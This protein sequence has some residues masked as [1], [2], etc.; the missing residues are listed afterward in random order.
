MA[1]RPKTCP[2]CRTRFVP[3][4]SFQPVCDSHE[5]R[6]AFV[7]K[8]IARDQARRQLAAKKKA[9][10]DKR[11]T[12]RRLLELQPTTYWRKKAQAVF[13]KMIRLVKCA[14]MPCISCG[15]YEGQMQAGHYQNAHDHPELAFE[16]D[17]VWIQCSR[18]NEK[19]S[20]NIVEYRKALVA[21]VGLER[22]EW[23]DS[24]QP[25]LHRRKDDYQQIIEASNASI[26]EVERGLR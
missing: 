2:E 17:N 12:R 5:C 4:R 13:N 1:R 18:C 19:K 15:T 3:S 26:K 22:V 6:V 9:R 7:Q 24:K 14:G 8:R 10:E 21:I 11:E 25:L 23:L 20:G 16:P